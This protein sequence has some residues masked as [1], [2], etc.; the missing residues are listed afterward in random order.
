MLIKFKSKF[1]IILASIF[2]LIENVQQVKGQRA[3]QWNKAACT[4]NAT[5]SPFLFAKR[6]TPK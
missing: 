5:N 2:N 6:Q 1:P 3:T 4:N